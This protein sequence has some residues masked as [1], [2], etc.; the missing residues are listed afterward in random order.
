MAWRVLKVSPLAGLDLLLVQMGF[1]VS[2]FWG[3]VS[4]FCGNIFYVVELWLQEQPWPQSF[5]ITYPR[6]TISGIPYYRKLTLHLSRD[7]FCEH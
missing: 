6:N 3:R 5:P 2:E 7:N 1:G 4:G